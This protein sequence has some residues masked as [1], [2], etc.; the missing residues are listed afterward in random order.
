[1]RNTSLSTTACISGDS[2][3]QVFIEVEFSELKQLY[4]LKSF[5]NILNGRHDLVKHF[6][7]HTVSLILTLVKEL[8]DVL[9]VH[10]VVSELFQNNT[11]LVAADGSVVIQIC[12]AEQD[13]LEIVRVRV[14]QYE[15]DLHKIFLVQLVVRVEAEPQNG[16]NLVH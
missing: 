10:H 9:L 12:C 2:P 14:V 15:H 16:V 13:L 4:S 5:K 6:V 7:T 3:L 11:E 8:R 1:M